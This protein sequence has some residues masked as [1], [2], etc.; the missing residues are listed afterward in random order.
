MKNWE[1][2]SDFNWFEYQ[3]NVFV[4]KIWEDFFWFKGFIGVQQ[5]QTRTILLKDG[6]L[7]CF[8]GNMVIIELGDY[9]LYGNY[10]KIPSVE[11]NRLNRTQNL[12]TSTSETVLTSFRS[13]SRL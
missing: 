10:Q 5:I 4:L 3:D 13:L 9:D 11:Y 1:K 12:S 8:K 6:V 7:Q 2:N